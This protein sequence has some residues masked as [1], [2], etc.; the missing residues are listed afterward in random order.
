VNQLFRADRG[1]IL[2][3]DASEPGNVAFIAK[4]SRGFTLYMLTKQGD[5]TFGQRS[6]NLSQPELR[7][8]DMNIPTDVTPISLAVGNEQVVVGFAPTCKETQ[9]RKWNPPGL[10]EAYCIETGDLEARRLLPTSLPTALVSSGTRL[11]IGASDATSPPGQTAATQSSEVG[12]SFGAIY[13]VTTKGSANYTVCRGDEYNRLW[14][15][16]SMHMDKV[17]WCYA[18][19][20]MVGGNLATVI[21]YAA[22]PTR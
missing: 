22:L 9:R 11:L 18:R 10:V 21:E 12:N 1:T 14:Q 4:S 15:P 6:L 5:E 16:M 2:E 3:F 13:A 17:S 8:T 7:R 19:M 20:Q